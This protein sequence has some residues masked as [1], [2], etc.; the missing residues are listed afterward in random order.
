ME[1]TTTF[2]PVTLINKAGTKEVVAET[3]NEQTA[4]LALG[5]VIAPV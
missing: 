3:E 4:L 2:T 5:Y 1:T